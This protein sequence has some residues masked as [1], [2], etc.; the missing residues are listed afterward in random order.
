MYRGE[1]RGVPVAIKKLHVKQLTRRA[2]ND[3]LKE[4]ELLWGLQHSALVKLY[5]AVMKQGFY[6][7]VLELMEG[8]SLYFML[9]DDDI[10][11]SL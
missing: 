3:Y 5:G 10:E 7:M 1:W 4:I 6:A 9:H 8:G 2:Q 11:L